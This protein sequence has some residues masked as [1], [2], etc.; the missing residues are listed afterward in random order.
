MK[1]IQNS[2][3]LSVLTVAVRGALAAMAVMPLAAMADDAATAADQTNPNN[4]IEVGVNSTSNSSAKFGEYNGLNKSGFLGNADISLKGGNAYGQGLGTD[5]WSITG[6]DLGTTSRNLGGTVGNQGKWSLG[7]DFDELQHN[8]TDTYQTPYNGS[9]GGNL[10]TLP[11]SFGVI[12]AARGAPGATA[13]TTDQRAAWHQVDVH[14]KRDTTSVKAGVNLDRQWSLAFDYKHIDQSGAKLIGSGSDAFTDSV[15]TW[16]NEKVAILMNP[17]NSQTDN[18]N[19]ALNWKGDKG[20]ASIGYYGSLYHDEYN[21]LSWSSPWISSATPTTGTTPNEAF[22]INSMSTPPSNQFHQLNM[23]GGYH[24]NP[25]TQLVGGLSYARNTQ[26]ESY[27]GTYSPWML[28]A[29]LPVGSLDASVIMKHADLKLTN[30]TTENLNLAAGLTYNER[31][32]HTGSN[33]YQYGV[34]GGDL[35][36]PINIPESWKHTQGDLSASYRIGSNQH[37]HA[38]YNY[39]EMQRWCNTDGSALYAVGA[40]GTTGS[41]TPFDGGTYGTANSCAQ[42]PK[43]TTNGLNLDYRMEVN[44]A[45]SFK[46][47]Y[48]YSKRDSDL[49]SIF[50]NPLHSFS[51]GYENMGFVAFFQAS[52]KEN[53][54]KLGTEWRASDKLDV[55]LNGKYAKDDY[56]ATFGVQQGSEYSVNLDANYSISEGN[57][58]DAYA[59]TQHRTRDMTDAS[60]R[61]ATSIPTTI[62]SNNLTDDQLMLGLGAKQNSLMGG[63]LALAEDIAYSL[64]KTDYS[65]QAGGTL[66]CTTVSSSATATT[67]CGSF[68]TIK[69]EDITLRLTGTYQVSKP[70]KVI[71]SYQ[72]EH[73]NSTDPYYYADY[74]YGYVS[75]SG[76]LPTNQQSPSYNVQE[77]FLAYSYSFK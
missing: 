57:S 54:V 59:T 68:P 65:T 1:T 9:M 49:N 18:F 48:A 2:L 23:S 74:Q 43:Q 21:G 24:I 39:D 62:F 27:A 70:A 25:T 20:F 38:A 73:L 35:I 7:V 58:V 30:Q 19:L 4:T 11:A 36:S 53:A 34:L 51:E 75:G 10:F 55:S 29:A 22:P 12:N 72:Y 6:T 44:D 14:S 8:I 61:T 56:D 47:G 26:N 40:V 33:M 41:V 52:R 28:N 71:L 60:G 31:D 13:L 17:T 66:A 50:Y 3:T 45:V 64:G 77:V 67:N 37:L 16:G 69:T 46:A 15:G 63:K 32:N 5:Y 76:I 42:V